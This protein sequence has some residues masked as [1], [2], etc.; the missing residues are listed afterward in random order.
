MLKAKSLETAAK[1]SKKRN[2]HKTVHTHTHTYTH[3]HKNR[4]GKKFHYKYFVYP[5]VNANSIFSIFIT[6][7]IKMLFSIFVF[8]H[9][10]H[11]HIGKLYR[12]RVVGKN[13]RKNSEIESGERMSV[14][15]FEFRLFFLF[16][17]QQLLLLCAS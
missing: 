10:T 1:Y 12:L 16:K 11:L 4:I 5:H 15:Q 6:N 17:F 7:K 2:L 9:T 3:P 8:P 13:S 14:R